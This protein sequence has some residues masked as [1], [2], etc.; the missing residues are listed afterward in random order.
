MVV[1]HAGR[2]QVARSMPLTPGVTGSP[3]VDPSSFIITSKALCV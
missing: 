1:A 3:E 2:S